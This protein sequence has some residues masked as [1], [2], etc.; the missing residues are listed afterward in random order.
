MCFRTLPGFAMLCTTVPQGVCCHCGAAHTFRLA[1]QRLG[2][3]LA[4]WHRIATELS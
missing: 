4:E 2:L 1:T 3:G